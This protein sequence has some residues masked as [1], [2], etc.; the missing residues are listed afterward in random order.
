MKAVA[1]C[2][3]MLLCCVTGRV[4]P[5]AMPDYGFEQVAKDGKSLLEWRS[6][7]AQSMEAVSGTQFVRTGEH[8]ARLVQEEPGK[9]GHFYSKPSQPVKAGEEYLLSFWVRGKG[10]AIAK[11]YLYHTDDKGNEAFDSTVDLPPADPAQAAAVDADGQWHQRQYRLKFDNDK[12]RSARFVI[13]AS[14]TVYVDD[15]QFISAGAAAAEAESDDEP[16]VRPN[17]ITLG[18]SKASPKVDGTI[19]DDEYSIRGSGL[20]NNATQDLYRLSNAYYLSQSQDRIYFA[21][22]LQ[23]PDGYAVTQ[24]SGNRDDP[25]LIA[26]KD[27]LY[28]FFR[29]DDAVAAKGYEGAYVGIAAN[30]TVY[31]AWEKVDWQ[32]GFCQRDSSFNASWKVHSGIRNGVWTVELSVPTK[33]LHLPTAGPQGAFLLSF[34]ANLQQSAVVWQIH[35]N[36]FDHYQAFGQIH[37]SDDAVVAQMPSSGNLSRGKLQP[38]FILRNEGSVEKPYELTY[39]VST[40]RMV[41]GGI[42]GYVFDQAL[43]QR[44]KEIVRGQSIY[45]WS[46]NGTILPGQEV[47]RSTESKLPKI[48][49]Y[50]LEI[51]ARAGG[52]AVA[53]QKIPFQYAPPIVARMTPVP[54]RELIKTGISLAGAAPEERGTMQILFKDK[55]GKTA[56]QQELP[57]DREEIDTAISMAA[58]PPGDY[59]VH[60]VL[61]TASG[62]E[63]ATTVIP[64]KKWETPD[65]LKERAGI[66]A[67]QPDWLPRPWTKIQTAQNRVSVWG[68]DFVFQPGSLLAGITSQNKNLLAGGVTIKYQHKG[69]EQTLSIS[70]PKFDSINNGRVVLSQTGQSPDFDLKLT[71][72]IE[73]DGMDR[74]D[75]TLTPKAA[76]LSIDKLWLELP[77]QNLPFAASTS[78]DAHFWQHG[79]AEDAFF[80]TPRAYRWI[81]LGNDDVGCAVFA[82]NYKGWIINSKKPRMTL[83]TQGDT[84]TLELRLVNEPSTVSGPMAITFGL[85][86]SPFKPRFE[87]WRGIR[88]DGMGLAPPPTNLVMPHSS[89]WNSCDSKPSPRNWAV[90]HD[91]LKF[92]HDRGQRVYPYIGSFF[93]SPYDCISRDFPFDPTQSPIPE[94]YRLYSKQTATRQEEYFYYA[95][96]WLGTP[97]SIGENPW[98]TRQEARVSPS[99]SYTDYFVYGV[100]Q[101]L[102][103][104]DLD[105]LYLDIQ[106]P[107][108]S[109]DPAKGH[110]V[111]TKDGVREGTAELFA[112]RDFYK[113]LYRVFEQNRGENSHPWFM[114][115]GFAA[116]APFSSF[117]DINFNGEE[118]KPDAPFQATALNIQKNLC[119][120][121]IA[122]LDPAEKD[123]GCNAYAYRAIFG[124]QFGLPTMFLPQYG[125]LPELNLPQHSREMLS[126]TFVHNN[127]LW[128]SYI[129]A[130]PVYDF[131]DKVEIPFGMADTE[132]FPYW[133]N[134]IKTSAPFIKASYWK[135]QNGNDY[136]VAIANW[137]DHPA[138]ATV[139][140]PDVLQSLKQCT[141]MESGAS[142]PAGRSLTLTIPAH[143][144]RVIR[145][146]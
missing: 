106:Q 19:S 62:N 53:Y 97:R 120:D 114:G 95:E 48:G 94:K 99:S 64:F 140:L 74:I 138:E 1:A 80:N 11:A 29:P 21:L 79:L 41:G 3:M 25:G 43:D 69:K 78:L 72:T 127:L 61:K 119:G 84:R 10:T 129:P 100:E 73:F 146:K 35:T 8:S 108:I 104:S 13:A 54:S 30:G 139:T 20:L 144:L 65:W 137:S 59:E 23:L 122:I 22:K 9:T 116:N 134:G 58:L 2:V 67:L 105:G 98:E 124:Q 12:I 42:G 27:V 132:F 17:L 117:W 133:S 86:P 7:N 68:R 37:L 16:A 109:F 4:E 66:D 32:K 143:D 136:L 39:L 38:N 93:I 135:K 47:K 15:A 36:W 81:W 33:E 5:A 145:L 92:L 142:I 113:R 128:P 44:N 126:L 71:Q 56:L 141:E 103:R 60:F 55:Q 90:L 82:D 121:P 28:L 83:R 49:H 75:L 14:G 118:I 45:H 91:M 31:D 112:T 57:A 131:W 107:M 111:I 26:A 46:D 125:Y 88:P 50:V 77:F 40:P 70:A 87:G 52:Q 76:N 89:I 34:G 6:E 102:K 96:D 85:Q 63:M 18:R 123:P 115:H 24:H 51:E 110:I 101:M 130:R